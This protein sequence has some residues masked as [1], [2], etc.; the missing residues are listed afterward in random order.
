[1]IVAAWREEVFTK[2]DVLATAATQVPAQDIEGSDLSLTW[3]LIRL[4]N[5]IN[6][7]GLPAISLPCGFTK[8]ALPIGL[9]LIGRWWDES[10]VFRAAHAYEQATDW[11]TR[12]P[13]V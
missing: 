4:T 13:P 5:P 11:H 7:L 8:A 10:T 3:A 9:Q 6:L 2:V 1:M 12:R